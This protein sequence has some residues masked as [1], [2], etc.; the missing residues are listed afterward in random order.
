MLNMFP[1]LL[2]YSQ[3]APFILR[4]VLGFVL[5]NLGYMK[6]RS[7]RPRWE[8][9]FEAL[10]WKPKGGFVTGFG[11][12]EMVGG[13]ALIVGFYTQLAALIF[14]VIF[15][16]ELYIEQKEAMLLKRDLV[17]YLLLFSI[18]LSLLFTGAGFFAFDLPL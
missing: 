4:V 1:E 5:F 14:V 2:T 3:F 7:E 9:F 6:L 13:L 8:I 10:G 17:F 15:F 12:L 18:A 11:L 16:I